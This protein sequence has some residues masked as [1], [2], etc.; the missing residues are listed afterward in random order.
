MKT[1][2]IALQ[3]PHECIALH[4]HRPRARRHHCEAHYIVLTATIVNLIDT[5]R[6]LEALN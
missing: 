3:L 1:K 5:W 2:P 6:A 4:C